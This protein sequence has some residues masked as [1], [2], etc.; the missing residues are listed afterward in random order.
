MHVLQSFFDFLII[1]DTA[2]ILSLTDRLF[3]KLQYDTLG[4]G[5]GIDR[6]VVYDTLGP[7]FKSSHR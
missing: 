2:T 1:T 4:S 7:G 3:A 6:A 5:R